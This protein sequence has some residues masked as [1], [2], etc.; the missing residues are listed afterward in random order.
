MVHRKALEKAGYSDDKL[1]K[2][3]T[4]EDAKKK[5]GVKKLIQLNSRRIDDEIQ[6][7]LREAPV[8]RAIDAAYDVAPTTIFHALVN[9]M[10]AQGCTATQIS[11]AL[12]SRPE[13]KQLEKMLVPALNNDNEP[14][15]DSSGNPIM[16]LDLPI[17]LNVLLPLVASY[18]TA[19][20]ASLWA[21]RDR[22]PLFKYEPLRNSRIN[23]AKTKIVTSI[24]DRVGND[25]GYRAD[26]RTALQQALKYG[27]CMVLPMEPYYMERQCDDK[28]KDYTVAEG[29]RMDIP[30]ISRSFL[31]QA[32]RHTTANYNTGSEYGGY[33]TV[34]RYGDV[35]A[36]KTLWNSDAIKG[37]YSDDMMALWNWWRMLEPCQLKFP[38]FNSSPK[39]RTEDAFLYT[40][41]NEDDAVT[42][43]PIFHKLVPKDWDLY[44]YEYPVWHRLLFAGPSTVVHV[45]PLSYNPLTTFLYDYD[46]NSVRPRSLA[47]ELMPWQDQLGNLLTQYIVSVRANADRIVFWN[48]DVVNQKDIN[49]LGIAGDRKVKGTVYIPYSR[50]ELRYGMQDKN[51]IFSSFVPPAFNTGEIGTAISMLLSTMER[52]LS[53][54]PQE[55]GGTATHEQSAHEIRVIQQNMTGRQQLTSSHFRDAEQAWKKAAYEAYVQADTEDEF[56]AVIDNADEDLIEAAKELKFKVEKNDTKTSMQITI[57]GDRTALELDA[58]AS[59]LEGADRMDDTKIAVAMVQAFQTMFSNPAIVQQIGVEQLV[60]MFNQMLGYIGVPIDFRL[61]LHPGAKPDQKPEGEEGKPP[62]EGGGEGQPQQQENPAAA[63]AKQLQALAQGMDEKLKQLVEGMIVPMGQKTS[64]AVQGITQVVGKLTQQVQQL[65][66]VTGAGAQKD[67]V[68]DQAI[69]VI[70]DQL[71]RISMMYA[72][73]QPPPPPPGGA[74][75]PAGPLPPPGMAGPPVPV[76]GPQVAGPV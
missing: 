1:K 47:L 13:G 45:A 62:G 7:N 3:F 8:Y 50:D 28:G 65:A 46:P 40:Q 53:F 16:R 48:S 2:L 70:V 52:A 72:P 61:R 69:K 21:E 18:L 37:G 35:A 68:Q 29:L 31:D 67:M 66:Q 75:G 56:D 55:V 14:L 6:R 58:F 59:E 43:A 5:D 9:D 33:W 23:R 49:A 42:L 74:I 11:D 12:K 44:D 38:S 34:R 25:L 24:I 57:R 10:L 54:A 30:H 4:A 32:H 71:K 76:G 73:N 36:D 63:I 27:R 17:F 15:K 39:D 41:A 51:D 26:L 22:H 64:E 20:W 60:L 19:R